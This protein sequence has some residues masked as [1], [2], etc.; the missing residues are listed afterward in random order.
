MRLH[1]Q[2]A[3]QPATWGSKFGGN[4]RF[5][6]RCC[7]SQEQL[8]A[9]TWVGETAETR[10]PIDRVMVRACIADTET[11]SVD[12]AERGSIQG[13]EAGAKGTSGCS[14]S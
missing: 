13:R 6:L 7:R 5:A 4:D 9:A 3:C 14:A 2:R 12:D 10:L 8:E 1:G 11:Q